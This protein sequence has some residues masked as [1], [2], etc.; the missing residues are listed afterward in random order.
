MATRKKSNGKVRP[1]RLAFSEMDL[2]KIGLVGLIL[3]VAILAGALNIGKVL[4]LVGNATYTADMT[5]AGGLRSGDDVR[6]AGIKVGKVN[7]VELADDHVVVTFGIEDIDLGDKT[8]ATVKSDNALGSKFLAVEPLGSGDIDHIAIERTDAGFAV[9][10]EL[11]KLTTATAEIDED[12]LAK[13][14]E[15]VSAVL[16]ATPTEFRS[17]LEGVSALSTTLSSRDSDLAALLDKASNVS[18]ILAERNKDITSILGDGSLLFDELRQ[19]REVLGNLL[20]NVQKAT[21]QLNGLATDNKSS[22]KPALTELRQTATLLTEYRSTLKL[23]LKATGGY[24][25]SLGESVAGGPFFQAYVANI[26][27]PEDLGTGGLA[28][29]LEGQGA[30]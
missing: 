19:R 15:S 8:R 21:V 6:V 26:G 17:A 5:E 28:G 12:A 25:R 14:F 27:S 23:A 3:T 16:N 10:E 13:S 4:S 9:N 22:L 24:I 7:G 11:G 18:S 29:L 2:G 20:R 1:M 30:F